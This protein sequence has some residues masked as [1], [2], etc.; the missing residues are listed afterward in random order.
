MIKGLQA[1]RR[2]EGGFTLIEVMVVIIMIGILAAISVPIYSNYVYRARA[3]EGVTTLGAIKTYLIERANATG[4]WPKQ[5]DAANPLPGTLYDEFK[6]FRDLYY[7]TIPTI[8]P[9]DGP[10]VAGTGAVSVM[11]VTIN[12]NVTNF[13]AS[14]LLTLTIDL[15]PATG[16]DVSGWGGTVQQKWASHL[17]AATTP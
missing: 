16:G 5:G 2:S 12:T 8:S 17:P 14:G 10:P 15:D 9:S 6:S 3:S 1:Q 7:F 11:T 13:G 4:Y